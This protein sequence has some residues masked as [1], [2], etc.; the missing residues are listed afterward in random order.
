M[1]IFSPHL[2]RSLSCC[3]TSKH[4]AL[5]FGDAQFVIP[6]GHLSLDCMFRRSPTNR[7]LYK[8][9]PTCSQVLSSAL[10]ISR[11]IL[12]SFFFFCYSVSC[13]TNIYFL[14]VCICIC[15][16]VQKRT[17]NGTG[18][19]CEMLSTELRS[20]ASAAC[21]VNCGVVVSPSSP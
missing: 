14:I 6:G 9:P 15:L 19:G 3:C 20:S 12:E 8:V 4:E 1:Q 10:F 17:Q 13:F 11:P 16:C 2:G 18:G 7:R 21:V 5:G